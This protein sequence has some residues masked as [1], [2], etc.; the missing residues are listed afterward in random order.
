MTSYW[1]EANLYT[2]THDV[3][4]FD[5]EDAITSDIDYVVSEEFPQLYVL[6]GHGEQDL[7]A[8]F[9]EQIEKENIETR[10][11]SLLTVDAIPEDADCVMIYAPESDISQDEKE[12]LADCAAEGG[13]LLVIAG[14][15]Q[16]GILENLYGLL[17][18]YGIEANE[19]VVVEGSREHYTFH[20]PAVLLPELSAGSITDSLIEENY[21]PVM[22]ISLGLT[23]TGNSGGGTATE[24][25]TTSAAAYSKL[26]GFEMTSYERENGDIAGPFALAVSA[27]VSGHRYWG[28]I[29]KKEAAI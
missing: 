8:S 23:V 7:P 4:G 26:A 9:S 25:L 16:E 17:N 22:P 20:G 3:T 18:D 1:G 27:A 19:G 13:R 15:V 29:E 14:P 2:G 28:S 21:Y 5:G 10:T 6:Q 12:L 24:L 11:L